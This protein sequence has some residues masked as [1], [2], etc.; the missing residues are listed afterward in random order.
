MKKLNLLIA[1]L[2]IGLLL[3]SCSK[4]DNSIDENS[5]DS[6][7]QNQDSGVIQGGTNDEGITVYK[8][9]KKVDKN[10][11]EN[12]FFTSMRSVFKDDESS[13]ITTFTLKETPVTDAIALNT[14][15]GF[16]TVG[17]KFTDTADTFEI[18][19]DATGRHFGASEDFTSRVYLTIEKI[20]TSVLE[21]YL[22][23][24]YEFN[25]NLSPSNTTIFKDAQSINPTYE[26][27]A[28]KISNYNSTVREVL[29]PKDN[30]G[31]YLGAFTVS[32]DF[33]YTGN[34]R[35]YAATMLTG[36]A[37]TSGYRV[38]GSGT[39]RIQTFSEDAWLIADIAQQDVIDGEWFTYTGVYDYSGLIANHYID[40]V[41]K[42]ADDALFHINTRGGVDVPTIDGLQNFLIGTDR[43]SASNL[44][45]DSFVGLID[46]LKFYNKALSDAE[47]M[48]IQ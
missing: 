39:N 12:T 13:E 2:S 41:K 37:L 25:N 14:T 20:D 6:T 17:N 45:D 24:T 44:A 15:N 22:V 42:S 34:Q 28:L 5:D 33:K 31:F 10:L 48:E 23:A 29:N 43:T 7:G 26:N 30:E 1:F 11:S 16:L 27:N 9:R 18:V 46:N 3:F 4:S 47:V 35:D 36:P 21:D 19:V 8:Y 40:G 38:L 32:F